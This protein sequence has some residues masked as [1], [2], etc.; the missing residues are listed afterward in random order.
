[1]VLIVTLIFENKKIQIKLSFTLV[2]NLKKKV[3]PDLFK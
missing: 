2:Q 3:T 1:M